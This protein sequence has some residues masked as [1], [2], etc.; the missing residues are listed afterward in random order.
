[1]STRE[2]LY[3]PTRAREGLTPWWDRWQACALLGL[4]I[5]YLVGLWIFGV[6][7]RQLQEAWGW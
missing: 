6:W 2:K 1:M 5:G 3:F 7:W 4:T